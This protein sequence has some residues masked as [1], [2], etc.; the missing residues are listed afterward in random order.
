[1]L[2]KWNLNDICYLHCRRSSDTIQT[3]SY[4]HISELGI[5]HDDYDHNN[6]FTIKSKTKIYHTVGT[7]P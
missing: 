2:N 5:H 6:C 3:V 7:V 1:V 4:I